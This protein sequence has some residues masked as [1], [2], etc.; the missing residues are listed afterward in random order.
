LVADLSQD[1]FGTKMIAMSARASA[2]GTCPGLA[3]RRGLLGDPLHGQAERHELDFGR[4]PIEPYP[5]I[6]AVCPDSELV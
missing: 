1:A 6:N 3:R 5:T 2:S 4:V